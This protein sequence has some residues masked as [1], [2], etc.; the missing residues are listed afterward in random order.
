MSPDW[1]AQAEPVP[2][3]KLAN[4][5]T[6][7]LYAYVGN[8]PLSG[9]DADG[10]CITDGIGSAGGSC[11]SGAGPPGPNG[12]EDAGQQAN[13]QMAG[14]L[15][16]ITTTSEDEAAAADEAQQQ[17]STQRSESAAEVHAKG[18]MQRYGGKPAS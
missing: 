7:N 15:G 1:S 12:G 11:Y 9:I 8:N 14:L 5:Q 10:H 4:P 13:A 6:L 18:N 16:S 2:Y 17:N 3:A